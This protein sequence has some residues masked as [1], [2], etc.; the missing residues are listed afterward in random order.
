M[1]KLRLQIFSPN[2]YV[3]R[4]GDIGREM[5]IVKRGKI[6]VVSEDGQKVFVTL[7]EG[8]VFGELSIMNIPGNKQVRGPFIISSSST[9]QL[10]QLFSFMTILLLSTLTT[11]YSSLA[12]TKPTGP[13]LIVS[14]FL[15]KCVLTVVVCLSLL[16]SFSLVGVVKA[17]Y[18]DCGCASTH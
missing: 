4:K 5:Y 2:D 9:F 7:G 15:A 17:G 16:K 13:L 10:H 18:D 1:L 6:A 12:C 3:C 8:A 14:L 11:T